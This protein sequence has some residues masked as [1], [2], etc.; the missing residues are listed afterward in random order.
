MD[1]HAGAFLFVLL[2]SALLAA[3]VAWT[4]AALYRRRMLSLMRGGP[5]P[6]QNSPAQ[7]SSL[8]LQARHAAPNLGLANNKRAFVRLLLVLSGLSLLVGLTQAG[9]ALQFVYETDRDFSARQWLV[10]GLVYAWPMVLAWG[11]LM[12]WPWSRLPLALTGYFAVLTPVVMLA[13]NQAQSLPDLLRL[14]AISAAIPLLIVLGIGASGRIRAIAPYLLPLFLAL[15]LASYIGLETLSGQIDKAEPEWSHWLRALAQAIGP[16]A[17][18]GLFAIGPWLLAAWPVYAL[19]RGLATAYR[20]KRHSDLLYLFGVYWLLVLAINA[21]T[22]LV[23]VG[24]QALLQLLGWFWLPVGFRLLRKWLTTTGPVP[25]L[26]VLRVFQ[27]DAEVEALFDRVVERWRLTGNT[28]LI[29]G[30]DL[31]SRTLDP[32]DLFAFLNGQLR[33]RFIASAAE[34]PRRVAELDLIPDPDGR[35]RINEVYCYDTTWQPALRALVESSDVVL[36]DLRGF[37]PEN[38][39]SRFEL[40]VLA[41]A[42]HLRRVVLLYDGAT[43]RDVAASE[44]SGASPERFV[45]L[46]AGRL[47]RAKAREVLVTLFGAPA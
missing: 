44:F 19:G 1:H 38:L 26:L 34:I 37:G 24:P 30:S 13:S 12:R 3:A 11:L 40:G 32:D 20:R 4:V 25:T 17:T 45:W 33:S 14:Y 9:L 2:L 43:A 36:M 6:D 22:G 5:P 10:V 7:S 47:D 15:L 29:A 35:Y 31:V 46:E 28:L 42:S 16:Y 41:G 39:G 8:T 23:A 21:L 27:R 18:L